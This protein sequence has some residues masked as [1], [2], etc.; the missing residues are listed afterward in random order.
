MQNPE[1]IKLIVKEKY[2][3]IAEQSRETNASSC[4]GSGSSCCEVD[5]SIMAENYGEKEGYVEDAD[6]GLGCGIPTDSATIA[7]GMTVLDLGSGAGNDAFV[8]SKLVGENGLVIGVDMTEAMIEKAKS[9]REKVGAVNTDFRLGEIE[10]LPVDSDSVDVVISN[11]VLNLVPDKQKAF[12]EIARVLK[13]GGKFAISDIVLEG[14]LNSTLQ[15]IAELYAGCVAGALQKDEYLSIIHK[16][17]FGDV[18][19]T[20]EKEIRLPESTLKS[21]TK[22]LP[23]QETDLG[24]VRI[25]SITV[26]A[27]KP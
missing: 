6:L 4:C 24:D 25:L 23:E 11:C 15:S 2:G 21:L 1:E 16:T 17:G 8:A 26:A 3:E 10:K 7:E 14:N 5:Y 27:A 22:L 19:I 18:R 12:E 13:P 20:K 9:N